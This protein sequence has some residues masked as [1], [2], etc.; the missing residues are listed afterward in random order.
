MIENPFYDFN[1]S[2]IIILYPTIINK[3]YIRKT[4]KDLRYSKW[5]IKLIIKTTKI[6]EASIT[7]IITCIL[8]RQNLIFIT[9]NHNIVSE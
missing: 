6:A 1:N 2:D 5:I 9:K 7:H 4:K 3:H 8:Q